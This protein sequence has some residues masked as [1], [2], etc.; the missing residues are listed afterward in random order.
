MGVPLLT[1]S[2]RTIMI[3]KIA[4]VDEN[5][6]FCP[7]NITGYTVWPFVDREIHGFRSESKFAATLSPFIQVLNVKRSHWITVCNVSM[8][9]LHSIVI[10]V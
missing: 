1:H 10:L 8:L 6:N 4:D 7:A 5:A 2:I 9:Y 3:R